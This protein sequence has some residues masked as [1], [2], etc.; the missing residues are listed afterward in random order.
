MMPGELTLQL[1]D[2]PLRV[3]AALE[4]DVYRK[5]RTGMIDYLRQLYENKGWKVG[6]CRCVI[7]PTLT[8]DWANAMYVGDAAGRKTDHGNT[9]YTMALNAKIKFA[10]PEVGVFG[11][12]AFAHSQEYFLGK[13]STYPVQPK[14]FRPSNMEDVDSSKSDTHV[15]LLTSVPLVVP[16]NTPITRKEKEL[17]IFVGPP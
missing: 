2:V 12:H 13:P 14:S 5:P 8:T 17:V 4:K 1:G 11:I 15:L 3:L 10:T 7:R 9:D 16:S 6:G